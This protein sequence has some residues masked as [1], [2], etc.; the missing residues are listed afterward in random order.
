MARI[1][2]A[3]LCLLVAV[4]GCDAAWLPQKVIKVDPAAV[5]EVRSIGHVVAQTTVDPFY[6]RTV[7][8]NN[9]LVFDFNVSD[10]PQALREARGLLR[11]L[12]WSEISSVDGVVQM[13]SDR[14]RN[15]TAELGDIKAIDELGA[16]LESKIEREIRANSLKSNSYLVISLSSVGE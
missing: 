12:G 6:E 16:T 8:V 2:F 3:M 15:I 5:D 7:Q 10:F 4:T 1:L 11:K 14:W 9:V 13:E